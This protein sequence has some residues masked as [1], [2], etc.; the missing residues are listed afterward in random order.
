MNT[1]VLNLSVSGGGG[2]AEV[3][4]ALPDIADTR[5]GDLFILAVDTDDYEQG[6]L[7]QVGTEEVDAV[8]GTIAKTALADADFRSTGAPTTNDYNYVGAVSV[9]P[10]TP[11]VGTQNY[12]WDL[13][14]G[15]TIATPNDPNNAGRASKL[16]HSDGN[17]YGGTWE[18]STFHQTS[19]A[20][21]GFLWFGDP[22]LITGQDRFSTRFGDATTNTEAALIAL[23]DANEEIQTALATSIAAS[24]SIAVFEIGGDNVYKITAYTPGTLA[25]TVTKYYS[26]TIGGAALTL[27][28][29][30]NEFGTTSTANKAAAE[31]LRDTY[32]T[33]NNDW[34]AEY[35]DNTDFFIELNWT[36]GGVAYQRRN[37]AG[38]GWEDVSGLIRGGKGAK[39]DT[40]AAGAK[41]DKGDTGDTGDTGSQGATGGQGATGAQGDTGGTG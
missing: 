25:G 23:L 31:T 3:V 24:N 27:G 29:E 8:A 36:G 30:T 4:E 16:V 39:G 28:P 15:R 32:A 6:Q 19:S 13:T 9:Q 37:A 11:A 5:E 17:V 20:A 14:V 38:D 22:D 1:R 2:R 35:N 10:A 18:T 40:G 12:F 34:L 7:V 41:G 33:A 26:G 21:E